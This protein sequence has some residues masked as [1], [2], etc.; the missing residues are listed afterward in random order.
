MR[1][2]KGN[3]LV[4]I[5]CCILAFGLSLSMPLTVSADM[6]PKP[7]VTIKIRNMPEQ[8]FVLALLTKDGEHEDKRDSF[9]E[10]AGDPYASMNRKIYDYDVDGWR[11][12]LGPGSDPFVVNSGHDGLTKSCLG[13]KARFSYYAPSYFK[14]MLVTEDGSQYVSNEITTTRFSAECIYDPVTGELV[15]N[16]EAYLERDKQDYFGMARLYLAGT[17]M[18]EGL[19]LILFGLSQARN[20]PFFFLGNILTQV[21]MHLDGWFYEVRHGSGGMA[22]TIHYII[23]EILIIAVECLLYALFMKQKDGKKMRIILYAIIANLVSMVTSLYIG[24]PLE[25]RTL[26]WGFMIIAYIVVLIIYLRNAKNEESDEQ[27]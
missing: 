1:K 19:L 2:Y 16:A 11:L 14:V 9:K 20:L 7:N 10:E 8:Q 27:I 12:A 18:V 26:F 6:G 3:V 23:K 4:W 24:G 17:L 21:Y 15:E 25:T 5:T 13:G 22:G